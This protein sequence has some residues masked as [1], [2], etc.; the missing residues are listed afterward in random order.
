MA[1]PSDETPTLPNAHS[2]KPAGG[3]KLGR[4]LLLTTAGVVACGGVAALTPIIANDVRQYT[5]AELKAAIAAAENN[6]RL[7]LLKEL[8]NL[9]GI[10]IDVAIAAAH[11]THL[12][13]QY[14]VLPITTLVTTIGVGALGVLITL[15]GKAQ[16]AL[17]LI[18]VD[19]SPLD[20]LKSMLTTWQGNLS[21]V[22]LDLGSFANADIQSAETYLT[23]LQ[24]KISTAQSQQPEPTPTPGV[25]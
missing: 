5:E 4:R 18:H 19:I 12:A 22:P 21:L 1:P 25:I 2:T 20:A 17:A 10:S 7:A 8:A 14:L 23:N 15:I 13:V 9:E 24:A 3:G 6:A 16:S 11:L